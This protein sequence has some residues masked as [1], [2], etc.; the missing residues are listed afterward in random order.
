MA[1]IGAFTF[2]LHSHLP[3]ARQAGMWP[4]GEEWVHEAI[5]DTY[6]PILDNLYSLRDAGVP[7]HLTIGITPILAEQLSDALVIEHFVSYAAERAAWAATD[8]ARFEQ[9]GDMALRDVARFYH[10]WYARVLT[11]FQDRY[12]R[13]ILGAFRT[14]QDEGL[15][16]IATSAAT[17]G[18]LPLAS[19]D[20]TIHAQLAVGQAAYERHFG[21]PA[22][23]VWLP[24]CAYRP[25]IDE[26]TNGDSVRRPGIERFLAAAGLEVFFSETHTVEGG[27]PVGKAA[28]EAIGPYAMIPRR[29]AMQVNTD[30]QLEPGTTFQPYW[31][32]DAAGQVAVLARNER[33]GKQVWSGTYG[34]PGDFCYREFHR[35]DGVSGLQYWRIGGKELD[36][37]EKPPYEPEVAQQRIRDHADHFVGLVEELLGN[38]HSETGKFGVI[39]SAY[40]TELFGHWWFEGADWL[41]AVLERLAKSESVELA[42]ASA[43]VEEHRPTEVLSLPESSWGA[44]GNHFTWLNVD[45]QW[46][47]PVIHRS[48]VRMEE[49]VARFPDAEGTLADVLNQAARELLLLESSDWPFLVTTGQAKDYATQR[50]TEHV[51]RFEKLADAAESIGTGGGVTPAWIDELRYRD[52]PFPTIDYRAF[53]ERQGRAD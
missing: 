24:E 7:F 22:T 2:V 1:K 49:L 12:Q 41:R 3:Y 40:D 19:R 42:S 15:I 26:G 31:V 36:L 35:K 43:M 53:A 11:S 20:S 25:A 34:Y 6:V 28:G 51:E 23:A 29:Y 32:G 14:L 16:E 38:Y 37:G 46:M 17:H 18:Y 4:H 5:A 48:E 45:T 33:T 47:W 30:V 10:H 39:S 8:V 9:S 27:A 13:N 52:N 21:K 50:F 44:G